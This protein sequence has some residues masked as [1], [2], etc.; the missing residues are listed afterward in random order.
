[1]SFLLKDT[2]HSALAE[3]LYYE[4]LS[5][6]SNYYYFLGRVLPWEDENSPQT[7]LNTLSYE[8]D[9][10]N[11]IISVKK[12][13]I[14]DVSLVVKRI[15]WTSGTV[16]DQFDGN[17]TSTNKSSTG[18]S[19]L[20]SSN[21]YV[22]TNNYRVYKC[23][24]N[25]LGA[26]S[27]VEPTGTD[28]VPLSTSDG[29]VWKYMYSIPTSLRNRFLTDDYMP[30]QRSITNA[31]YSDGELN[32]ISIDNAGSGYLG[33]TTVTLQVQGIFKGGGGNSIANLIPVFNA[34]GQFIDVNIKDRGNNYFS[35]N[36]KIIDTAN[37]GTGYYN[38]SS[39]A[40]L[41]PFL[42]NTQ[43]DRVVI[44]DPG[45]GYSAN[46]QTTVSI[47]GDGTGAEA[48]AFINEAGELAEVIVTNRG[49]GYT[50]ADVEIVGDG[51]NANAIADFTVGDLDTLQSFVELSALPGAIYNINIET[52]GNNYS[53]ANVIING[54]GAGFVGNI[55]LDTNN[56]NGILKINVTN[57][58]INYSYANVVIQGS[59]GSGAKANVIFSPKNGHGSD[60]VKE[61]FADAVM[62]YSTIN[63]EK[64]QGLFVNN[65]FRQFGLI[66]DIEKFDSRQKFGNTFGSACFLVTLNSTA[67]LSK[68]L[69][70]SLLSDTTR[71]FDVVEYNST[72]ALLVS[73]NNKTLSNNNVLIN[74]AD[75]N[76][77]TITGVNLKP[78]INKFSGDL[79]FI[80]N[81]TKISYSDQQVV[82]IKTVI[83]L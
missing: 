46:L 71:K 76:L 3:T 9:T 16:Y 60:A 59:S 12:I 1:M 21:F 23:L 49:N 58:G 81:K 38:T 47:I 15:N 36:I 83:K 30:V 8:N 64:N 74:L 80:D 75:D 22:L 7:P 62:F 54:D 66:K 44:N 70:L 57:P 50:Y 27:T 31:Y 67:G 68:D 28:V 39:T 34:Q 33:N 45:I 6:R 51:N 26:Q 48:T 56:S 77:F 73:K 18:A 32:S 82:T 17:Y 11:G 41:V 29:Y 79:I 24:N 53:N 43:V 35:A 72:Q 52:K 78:A 13:P 69:E 61:L 20:K 5:R 2:I 65:D 19:S 10:R 55:V 40:N 14:S 25:N 37:T 42:Y 4:V 63:Y